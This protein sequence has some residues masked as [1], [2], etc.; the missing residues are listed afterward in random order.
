MKTLP[1]ECQYLIQC[2]DDLVTRTTLSPSSLTRSTIP[3]LSQHHHLN[4][5]RLAT[6]C[7]A[8]LH[9]MNVHTM[10]YCFKFKVYHKPLIFPIVLLNFE[11]NLN[12]NVNISLKDDIFF[13]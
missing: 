3:E 7:V 6:D 8:I 10:D 11:R 2:Y 1:K 4:E 12:N 9:R 5:T 13:I